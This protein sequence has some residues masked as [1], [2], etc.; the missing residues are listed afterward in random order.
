MGAELLGFF[1]HPGLALGRCSHQPEFRDSLIFPPTI[2]QVVGDLD[3]ARLL[4]E[5]ASKQESGV[6][7]CCQTHADIR[8]DRMAAAEKLLGAMR[9][10]LGQ[11]QDRAARA[12]RR[13]LELEAQTDCLLQQAHGMQ[14]CYT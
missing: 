11:E 4:L 8:D 14:V 3:S 7:A 10:E 12:E 2:S 1:R 9:V 5:A 6:E 13:V